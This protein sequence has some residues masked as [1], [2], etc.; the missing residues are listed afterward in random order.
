MLFVV[1]VVVDDVVVVVDSPSLI[2]TSSIKF[3]AWFT[4][5]NNKLYIFHRAKKRK[6]SILPTMIVRGPPI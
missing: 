6:S 1:V 4:A 5:N 2:L 3:E